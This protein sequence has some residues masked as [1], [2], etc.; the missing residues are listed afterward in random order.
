MSIEALGPR[1]ESQGDVNLRLP[2]NPV[3]DRYNVPGGW[4]HLEQISQEL[5]PQRRMVVESLMERPW[6][7]RTSKELQLELATLPQ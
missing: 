4:S 7:Q 1:P 3:V 5:T 2:T 6:F